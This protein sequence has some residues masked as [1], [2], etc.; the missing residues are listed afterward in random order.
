MIECE[1]EVMVKLFGRWCGECRRMEM[2][3]GEILGGYGE[4][5][6]FEIKKDDLAEVGERYE[7]M[8][9]ASV[10]I[11]KNGEKRGDLESGNGKSGE[12]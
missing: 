8:G 4:D 12:E 1:K 2:L 6:W 10:L 11:L 3:I 9:I 7:V 5:E